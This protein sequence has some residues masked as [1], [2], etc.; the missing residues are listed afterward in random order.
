M[1]F[2]SGICFSVFCI[3]NIWFSDMS[4]NI[5]KKKMIFFQKKVVKVAFL[6]SNCPK[7]SNFAPIFK[8]KEKLCLL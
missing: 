5:F 2:N 4:T 6:A 3:A 1:F 8:E 7:N